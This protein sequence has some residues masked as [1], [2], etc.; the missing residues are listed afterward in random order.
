MDWNMISHPLYKRLKMLAA[1]SNFTWL[2]ISRRCVDARLGII[3][4]I[5]QKI[6]TIIFCLF[7]MLEANCKSQSA[8]HNTK[9]PDHFSMIG[10]FYLPIW[11]SWRELNSWPLECHSSA[12]PTELQPHEEFG[13]ILFRRGV[14]VVI[15]SSQKKM[16][17][18]ERP[19][20]CRATRACP[21][22]RRRHR[23][24]PSAG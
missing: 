1:S 5:M 18:A 12:L 3:L 6:F 14:Q 2:M 16:P 4:E 19:W 20:P 8:E 15:P 11:W 9:T 21:E 7:R 13:I 10:G 24:S 23:Q 22:R 17:K